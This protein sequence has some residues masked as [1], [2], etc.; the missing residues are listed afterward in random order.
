[1][2]RLRG[3]AGVA[4]LSALGCIG[5]SQPGPVTLHVLTYNIHHGAGL[6]GKIDLERIAKVIR[7]SQ[8]DLVALQEVDRGTRR[9]S[10][11]DQPAILAKLAGM[12]AVF[13]KNI[14]IQDG[15]YGNAVL[16]RRPIEAYQ[17]HLLPRFGE[18]EQRGLLEV[19]VRLG[20]R[21]LVF[22]ATHL[23]HRGDDTERLASMARVQELSARLGDVPVILAGDLNATPDS[24]VMVEA[25][26]WLRDTA[27]VAEG[28]PLSFPANQP[29][30]RI[31]YILYRD[32]PQ[33]RCVAYRVLPEAVAS[34]HR[35]VLAVIEVD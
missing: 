15:E 12:Q 11:A 10:D 26:G 35:P 4:L 3:L 31:D 27:D 34:D 17:N 28:V 5:C 24:R 8:A 30:R 9:A 7:E 21:K 29:D 13:E 32:D 25:A 20:R 14:N 6:D 2:R 22:L 33:M 1:M 18:S 23:D 16:S 19:H